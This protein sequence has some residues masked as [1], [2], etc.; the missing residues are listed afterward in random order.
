MGIAQQ[1]FGSV[2][3]Q[4]P[5]IFGDSGPKIF[6]ALD[7]EFAPADPESSGYRIDIER[8]GQMGEQISAQLFCEVLAA[9][10]H[11]FVGQGNPL[12]QGI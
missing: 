1:F 9:E 10:R 5:D 2:Y 6:A 3:A 11:G 8:I 7:I 4:L 12:R